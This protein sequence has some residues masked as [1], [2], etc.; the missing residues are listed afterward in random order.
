LIITQYRS[1]LENKTQIMAFEKC[2]SEFK[3]KRRSTTTT[4]TNSVQIAI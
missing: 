2:S 3:E 4:I 1:E